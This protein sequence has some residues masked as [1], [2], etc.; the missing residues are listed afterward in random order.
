M[1]AP[2]PS[3]VWTRL[4]PVRTWRRSSGVWLLIWATG[5][6]IALVLLIM[7]LS[8]GIDLLAHQGRLTVPEPQIEA[9]REFADGVKL[10]QLSARP[11]PGSL[12]LTETGVA[13]ERLVQ[14]TDALGQRSG[15]GLARLA[16]VGNQRRSLG[17]DFTLAVS[18]GG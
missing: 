12:Q 11:E 5:A 13:P 1:N 14:P 18:A 9:F 10:P 16:D 17:R 2:A 7:A 8:L 6:A 4:V 15:S 3:I